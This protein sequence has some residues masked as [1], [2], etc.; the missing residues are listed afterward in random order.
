MLNNHAE[1]LDELLQT[2]IESLDITSDE[3]R[4]AVSRYQSVA[5][6]LSDYWDESPQ[7]G[8]VYPQGSMRLGTVTRNIHRNDEI[9]LDLV[10]L[11]D[12]PKTATTQASLKSDTGTG[13]TR[14]VNSRP[15]GI[16]VLGEGK[17]CWT[18]DYNG[19][20]LDVLPALPDAD[21]SSNTGIIITDTQLRNWQFS[22]PIGYA[23]WFHAQMKK[24]L[25]D[26][27]I[28]LSKRMDIAA[29][30]RW[31]IKTTLQRAVQS[32]KRHR[33]IYF[34]GH[35][36]DRPASVILT[37][38][39]AH[40]YLGGGTLYEVLSD[41]SR[42]MPEFV[43]YEG[44]RAVIINPVQPQENFADRWNQHPERAEQFFQWIDAAASDFAALGSQRG[45][46]QVLSKMRNAFGD[47][48]VK[49][50][51]QRQGTAAFDARRAGALVMTRGTGALTT[52]GAGRNVRDH[53]FH[54]QTR[55]HG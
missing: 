22:N 18:L 37:T 33:D 53:D 36:Q 31:M 41:I 14:F 6:S 48:A 30:P 19:F 47:R 4:L 17:R 50:A 16:P 52:A 43:Q 25:D 10:A 3:H 5:G 11:R 7:D 32:L 15:E 39:A 9:D 46:D 35:L 26:A 28:A 38:L 44:R 42:R 2:G 20:H 23:D 54:L 34:T 8:A 1:T 55:P 21:A 29:V 27:L 45:L 49:A 40:C 24:E 12:L 51:A 13:L